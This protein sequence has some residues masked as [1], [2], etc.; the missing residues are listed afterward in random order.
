MQQVLLKVVNVALEHLGTPLPRAERP[1]I[2]NMEHISRMLHIRILMVPSRLGAV[3]QVFLKVIHVTL[4][5]LSTPFPH[6]ESSNTLLFRE[7]FQELDSD[8]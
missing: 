8:F 2:L 5:H 6:A 4:E 7:A 3:Q 1:Y